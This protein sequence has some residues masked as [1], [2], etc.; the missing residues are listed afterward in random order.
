MVRL[1]D[2]ERSCAVLIGASTY[3]SDDLP[4]L[5]A[6]R[7]NLL[8]MVEVLTNPAT[9][10]FSRANCTVVID[11]G[12]PRTAYRTLRD[13]ARRAEDTLL[14]YFAGHG[15]TGPLRHELYL[16]LPDTDVDELRVSALPFE[17]IREVLQDCPATNRVLILDCCFSGLAVH[18]HMTSPTAVLSGQV[19]V[20]G[21][22]TLASTS[23][24]ATAAAPSGESYTAFTGELLTVLRTGIPDGPELLTLGTVYRHLRHTLTAKGLPAPTQRGTDTADLLALARNPAWRP[25]PTFVDA[26]PDDDVP[27]PHGIPPRTRLLVAS[28]L[29]VAIVS[30][31]VVVLL[32][33][34]GNPPASSRSQPNSTTRTLP[35]VLPTRIT[36]MPEATAGEV[37]LFWG[38]AWVEH[39]PKVSRDA[40]LERLRP[41]TTDELLAKLSALD[42][43]TIPA[44]GVIGLPVTMRSHTDSALMSLQTNGP[45]LEIALLKVAGDWLVSGYDIAE[46]QTVPIRVYNNSTTAGLASQA[47]NDLREAGWDVVEVGNYGQGV[48]PTTTVYYR[49]GTEEEAAAEILAQEFDI[50]REPRFAGIQDVSAGLILIVTGSYRSPEE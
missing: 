40:W 35:S 16:A 44:T 21:T 18:D 39:P 1:P 11:S 19:D 22:Y 45:E 31:T 3:Q 43:E 38:L 9:S 14:V 49:P 5:P 26:E 4:N 50:R 24:N 32:G 8:G 12:S 46:P 48:I 10:G 20:S 28:A 17:V 36:S 27:T 37:T 6:V 25:P 34:Q 13:H 42:P 29:A 7:N 41:Y 2:P 47:T 33:T 15:L 30:T 23:A